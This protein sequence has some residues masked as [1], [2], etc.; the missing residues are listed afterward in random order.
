LSANHG[1]TPGAR[2][3]ARTAIAR[4]ILTLV[5]YGLRDGTIRSKAIEAA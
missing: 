3:I 2:R 4:K 1:N 5:Y